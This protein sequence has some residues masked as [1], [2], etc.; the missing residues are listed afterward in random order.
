MAS[1]PSERS[2]CSTQSS[3]KAYESAKVMP[4]TRDA[5]T[6]SEYVTIEPAPIIIA[7]PPEMRR[8]TS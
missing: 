4:A 1:T 3:R 2:A 6:Y 7:P 8:T 5:G